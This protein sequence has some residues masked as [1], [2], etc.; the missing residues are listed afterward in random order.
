MASILNR[1][2]TPG[3]PT[4][5]THAQ[6]AALLSRA[7]SEKATRIKVAACLIVKNDEGADEAHCIVRCLDALRQLV[8]HV[9]VVYTARG[10]QGVRVPKLVREWC[11]NNDKQLATS[12]CVWRDDFAE[13][14][15][16]SLALA[17]ATLPE[18]GW[19]FLIDA[20]EV[21]NGGR[22]LDAMFKMLA[23][24]PESVLSFT[25]PLVFGAQVVP[26]VN[27]IRNVAGWSYKFRHHETLAF[28][29]G[30]VRQII[31]GD[32]EHP[33]N[34]PY[35]STPHDGARSKDPEKMTKEIDTLRTA[36]AETKEPRYLFFLGTTLFNKEAHDKQCGHADKESEAYDVLK[37]Y[38]KLETE[39]N[40]LGLVYYALL[41]MGRIK[42]EDAE[43]HWLRAFQLVPSR[44][45]A[46]GELAT[47]YGNK[48][49]WALAYV[50]AL[51]AAHKLAPTNVEYIEP[52]WLQWRALDVLTVALINIGQH[53]AALNYLK[54]LLARPELPPSERPRVQKHH[55]TIAGTLK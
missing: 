4:E 20:D 14:R 35:V 48:G 53:A 13:A 11:L 36:W 29:G 5:A 28:R 45:E 34:G 9:A 24:T 26:R 15:N 43:T 6:I 44:A 8:T 2:P 31:M 37:E 25:V 27:L 49:Q 22:H 52:V 32:F 54:L 1:L 21:F 3:T 39:P 16:E 42:P 40:S 50:Y 55:D 47:Y 18:V 38:A 12:E 41:L 19:L 17:S 23:D 10:A 7:V 33:G 30:P 51:A 46:P